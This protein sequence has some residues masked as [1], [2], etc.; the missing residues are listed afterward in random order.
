MYPYLN[1]TQPIRTPTQPR[2]TYL[3][4][5]RFQSIQA[6]NHKWRTQYDYCR[7]LHLDKGH[8][9]MDSP[10]LKRRKTLINLKQILFCFIKIWQNPVQHKSKIIIP[11]PCLVT[12]KGL[13]EHLKNVASQTTF[14]SCLYKAHFTLTYQSILH[15]ALVIR[16]VVFL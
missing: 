9:Y 13:L 6:Y 14:I 2:C 16:P 15:S 3:Y 4:R 8:C 11:F 7:L 10:L 1:P 12:L 5:I